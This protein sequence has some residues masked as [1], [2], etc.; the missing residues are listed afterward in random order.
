MANNSQALGHILSPAGIPDDSAE[1]EIT[2]SVILEC[3]KSF[4]PDYNEVAIRNPKPIVPEEYSVKK[5]GATQGKST[6][7]LI[8]IAHN[9]ID[10]AMAEYIVK[11]NVSLAV[12]LIRRY[13]CNV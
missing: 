8:S 7:E 6:Q 9:T 5:L 13:I 3:V 12:Y 2:D 1:R 4:K 10:H 11:W